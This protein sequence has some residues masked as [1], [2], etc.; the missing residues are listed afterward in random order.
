MRAA[1]RVIRPEV[2]LLTSRWVHL[3]VIHA[4]KRSGARVAEL[5]H[6]VPNLLGYKY[7]TVADAHVD[8]DWMLTFGE[9]WND[10]DWGLPRDRV[11]AIGYRHL[12]QRRSALASRPGAPTAPLHDVMLVSQPEMSSRLAGRFE[13]IVDG[14]RDLRFLLKLHPQ[15]IHGW[16]QRYPVG[17][18]PNVVVCDS[19]SADILELFSKCRAVVG[20]NSTALF[21]ASFFGLRVGI[22]NWDGT[23]NCPA[24]RYAG[25]YNLFELRSVAALRAMLSAPAT[26]PETGNPFLADFDARRF[27]QLTG[28]VAMEAGQWP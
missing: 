1:M 17:R 3:P 9:Y 14:N 16:A 2:V 22:L 11:A 7:S 18:R 28:S 12:W 10:F 24:L 23:N 20:H 21:E 26:R 15:D 6:G 27:A 4:A 25:R 5:Q 19:P 8:P 13:E